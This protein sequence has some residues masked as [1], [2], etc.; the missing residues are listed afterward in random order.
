MTHWGADI[1]MYMVFAG[2]FAVVVLGGMF[3]PK[4]K[5]APLPQAGEVW[6]NDD[7]SPWPRN[8]RNVVEIL[9]V[10]EGWVL[11]RFV[12]GDQR[13]RL[14]VADFVHARRRQAQDPRGQK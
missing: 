6:E 1:W 12:Y 7:G 11:Y 2:V 9:E 10:R 13:E 14:K 4:R 5:A 8:D 3:W